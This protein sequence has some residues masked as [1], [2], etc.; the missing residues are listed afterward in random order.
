MKVYILGNTE[1]EKKFEEAEQFI[2]QEGNVPI[3]PIKIAYALPEEIN[4]SELTVIL[5]E[6][7]RVCDAVYPL[8]GWEKDLFARLEM[9]QAE[10]TEKE[11]YNQD[12]MQNEEVNNE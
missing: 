10:H 11:I 2:R 8:E 6:V 9:G 4:N 5:F 3:N 12:S 7:I 1:N